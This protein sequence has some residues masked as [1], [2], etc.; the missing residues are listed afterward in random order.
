MDATEDTE[1]ENGL[2]AKSFVVEARELDGT[3]DELDELREVLLD[4]SPRE[5]ANGLP[6]I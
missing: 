6:A 3:P 4:I 2:Y 5:M 1:K